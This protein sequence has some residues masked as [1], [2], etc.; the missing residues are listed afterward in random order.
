MLQR[1]KTLGDMAFEENKPLQLGR[2]PSQVTHF[3][4]YKTRKK[5]NRIKITFVEM[6]AVRSVRFYL[7]FS[8]HPFWV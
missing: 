2:A 3:T 8:K 4:V 1:N 5:R 7:Y 6:Q